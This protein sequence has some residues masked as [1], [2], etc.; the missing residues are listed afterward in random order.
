VALNHKGGDVSLRVTGNNNGAA[1]RYGSVGFFTD[2]QMVMN[3]DL[4]K[5]HIQARVDRSQ[6]FITNNEWLQINQYI[7]SAS[8]YT[9]PA[10]S[11]TCSGDTGIMLCVRFRSFKAGMYLLESGIDCAIK[12]DDGDTVVALLGAKFAEVL[13]ERN[14]IRF[15][16]VQAMSVRQM[17]LSITEHR[18]LESEPAVM[19]TI[20]S[21]YELCEGIRRRFE[22]RLNGIVMVK[23]KKKLADVE[24]TALDGKDQHEL[25]CESV[26]KED[27]EKV[28]RLMEDVKGIVLEW[29]GS[30]LANEQRN[31][32]IEEDKLNK[33]QERIKY[34]RESFFKSAKLIQAAWRGYRVREMLELLQLHRACTFVQCRTRGFLTRSSLRRK[35]INDIV[36]NMQRV[37][38]GFNGRKRF[39]RRGK[40]V[41]P[42]KKCVERLLQAN[43]NYDTIISGISSQNNDEDDNGI[44]E[45]GHHVHTPA[46]EYVSTM[47]SNELDAK[48]LVNATS[49][50]KGQW[51]MLR[52]MGQR[53]SLEDAKKE[54]LDNR[55]DG[56]VIGK[57]ANMCLDHGTADS[58]FT[59]VDTRKE[60]LKIA[61]V[62]YERAEKAK[63]TQHGLFCKRRGTALLK[64]VQAFDV[65]LKH[66]YLYASIDAFE[67]ALKFIEVT[68][69]PEVWLDKALAQSFIGDVDAALKTTS[70]MVR[71]FPTFAK[72]DEVSMLAAALHLNIGQYE[73]A[74]SYVH[75]A[76]IAGRGASYYSQ[77]DLIMIAGRINEKWYYH[78]D[79]KINE[80]EQARKND[81]S[82][83][84][85]AQSSVPSSV[86]SSA[87]SSARGQ[88]G[89]K[90]A[91]D[92]D[93]EDE[94]I[95]EKDQKWAA[96]EKAYKTV[97]RHYL[98]HRNVF[99][100][101]KYE[102]W[103][104]HPAT[105]VRVATRAAKSGHYLLA[106]DLYD[107]ALERCGWWKRYKA[108]D[109][110]EDVEDEEEAESSGSEDEG[111]K[112]G[113]E[114]EKKEDAASE[115]S[116]S[117]SSEE[118]EEE[119][120][121]HEAEIH[122]HDLKE[123]AARILYEIAKCWY[124][125]GDMDIAREYLQKAKDEEV[126]TN[127]Q[128]RLESIKV[129]AECWAESKKK[130][131]SLDE[132]IKVAFPKL[133]SAIPTL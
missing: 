25:D 61:S 128:G 24:G 33:K 43:S 54:C 92:S 40:K 52:Y 126:L 113:R 60:F 72:M 97:F 17:S 22:V 122:I 78:L 101:K 26:I 106:A 86:Q 50:P 63:H 82:A 74:L 58:N 7:A 88:G 99:H 112:E 64:T 89:V 23:M 55:K 90:F 79:H 11:H 108:R 39:A 49:Q 48:K 28:V 129:A 103:V 68:V 57:L 37:G 9:D 13:K 70:A 87:Q 14:E 30:K 19:D 85:S 132:E 53:K 95:V 1:Y 31:K 6:I 114:D 80:R 84:S 117:V 62:L 107:Q 51:A 120:I 127:S 38:R 102:S 100:K 116:I 47:F 121:H 15:L 67:K 104:S 18:L 130:L 41:Y 10:F 83:E 21:M 46:S 3:G 32:K 125:Q 35:A 20:E 59:S 98:A 8:Q 27:I 93:E 76:S 2:T 45:N 36:V 123:S 12:N 131:G 105:W 94:E 111:N 109:E 34:W 56:D 5:K 133:I 29:D 75:H 81:G 4:L 69:L 124:Y 73:K 115:D 96:S 77:M 65:Q 119:E 44:D 91:E 110:L 16:K 66:D 42:S 71:K 118:K